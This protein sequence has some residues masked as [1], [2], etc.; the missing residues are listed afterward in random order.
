ME[1]FEGLRLRMDEGCDNERGAVVVMTKK[2]PC[3]I[4]H[5]S[6]YSLSVAIHSFLVARSQLFSFVVCFR[7]CYSRLVRR[8]GIAFTASLCWLAL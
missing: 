5:S 4:A 2:S 3:F 1:L 8:F 7:V 6:I